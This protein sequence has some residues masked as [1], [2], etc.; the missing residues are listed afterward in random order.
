MRS[1]AMAWE[2]EYRHI[3]CGSNAPPLGWCR[4]SNRCVID[5]VY[6]RTKFQ[7][8]VII[9]IRIIA[10]TY[11]MHACMSYRV[12]VCSGPSNNYTSLSYLLWRRF[13][14]GLSSLSLSSESIDVFESGSVIMDVGSLS[15]CLA[16]YFRS[17]SALPCRF[18]CGSHVASSNRYPFQ[19]TIDS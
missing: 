9:R 2:G 14:A 3:H 18:L 16:W 1:Y 6:F 7:L 8:G 4:G 12:L 17:R 13:L 5:G 10:Y 15:P 19:C 11:I